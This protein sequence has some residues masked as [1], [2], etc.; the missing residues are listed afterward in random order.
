MPITAGAASN[1]ITELRSKLAI[2]KN[3]VETIRANYLPCD[4][5]D[6]EIRIT[7]DDGGSCVESHFLAVIADVEEKCDEI[8]EELAQWEGLVFEPAQAPVRAIAPAAAANDQK[9]RPV[10]RSKISGRRLQP[11]AAKQP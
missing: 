11:A 2:Y 5:G 3:W 4:G 10:E 6:A 1:K 8:R 9:Q 7:R